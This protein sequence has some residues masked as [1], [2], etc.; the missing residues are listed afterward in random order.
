[1]FIVILLI[2][3]TTSFGLSMQKLIVGARAINKGGGGVET[4]GP[5]F[6]LFIDIGSPNKPSVIAS[7]WA[8]HLILSVMAS[9]L[10]KL[11]VNPYWP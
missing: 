2:N 5:V 6:R 4:S 8:L 11:I 7:I 10:D 1:M 3:F 9:Q